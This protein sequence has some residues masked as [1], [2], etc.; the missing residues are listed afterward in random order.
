MEK[1]NI[2]PLVAISNR[3]IAHMIRRI[4]LDFYGQNR[5]VP[6]RLSSLIYEELRYQ[7]LYYLENVMGKLASIPSF[8]QTMVTDDDVLQVLPFVPSKLPRLKR[9][10]RKYVQMATEWKAVSHQVTALSKQLDTLRT[11]DPDGGQQRVA[12]MAALRDKLDDAQQRQEQRLERNRSHMT[13]EGS[14]FHLPTNKVLRV[15]ERVAKGAFTMTDEACLLLH[16]DVEYYLT[17]V[18]T[19]AFGVMY[20]A[21]RETL[22]PKDVHVAM[23]LMNTKAVLRRPRVAFHAA[24]TAVSFLDAYIQIRDSLQID[25]QGAS[26]SLVEQLDRFNHLLIALVFEYAGLYKRMDKQPTVTLHHVE[27]AF[28]A[29][30]PSALATDVKTNVAKMNAEANR[31]RVFDI[32]TD[33]PFE[34]DAARLLNQVVEYLNAELIDLMNGIHSSSSFEVPFEND[35]DLD[36]LRKNLEFVIVK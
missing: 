35:P 27:T 12:E 33:V 3:E 25:N 7:L 31:P 20:H 5:F 2:D 30:L 9:C 34:P 24:T 21:K 23:R 1:A 4:H 11:Q 16:F 17:I 14:C 8:P 32:R 18:L 26:L 29:I 15:L 22:L 13:A 6:M 10:S 36:I 28:S 19:N